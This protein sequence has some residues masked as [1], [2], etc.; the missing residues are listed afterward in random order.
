MGTPRIYGIVR[1]T[2][3]KSARWAFEEK[4][5]AYELVPPPGGL[6]SPEYGQL[7]PF[8]RIPALEY[9]GQ[10]IYEVAAICGFVDEAFEGPALQ[11]ADPF[12]RARMRQ[13]ISVMTAYLDPAIL[14]GYIFPYAFAKD[15]QVDQ[16][17]IKAALPGC[18]RYTAV[19]DEAL[20]GKDFLA[21]GQ[22]TIADIMIGPM[23]WAFGLFP[24]GKAILEARP[25]LSR[26]VAGWLARPGFQATLSE[27]AKAA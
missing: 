3:A 20:A 16:A 17:A 14:R 4:G 21:G 9:D 26:A 10:H 15:G 1:S 8:A 13:W 24:E 23:L 12:E 22:L 19:L 5:V 25:N 18:E 2:Y 7:H 6:T 27:P 11:P